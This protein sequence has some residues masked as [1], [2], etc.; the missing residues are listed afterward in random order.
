MG[1]IEENIPGQRRNFLPKGP[2]VGDAVKRFI[3]DIGSNVNRSGYTGT[4]AAEEALFETR[5]MLGR[6][7]NST[8]ARI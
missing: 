6:L 3:D 1:L 7:F 4:L 5:E 8:A 2:G